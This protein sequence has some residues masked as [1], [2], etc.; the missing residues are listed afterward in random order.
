[1][2]ECRNI[3][4]FHNLIG[5]EPKMKHLSFIAS[6]A[7][8]TPGKQLQLRSWQENPVK[9]SVVYI[10]GK[11]QAEKILFEPHWRLCYE[12]YNRGEVFMK[13]W[14][15]EE[16]MIAKADLALKFQMRYY[17]TTIQQDL[18]GN[19]EKLELVNKK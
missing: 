13:A 8:V 16:Y 17:G 7:N 3:T 6:L 12:A 19:I 9:G 10:P 11:T 18:F 4:L 14:Q 5:K 15:C 2:R 1:M